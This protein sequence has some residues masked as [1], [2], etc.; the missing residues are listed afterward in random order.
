MDPRLLRTLAAAAAGALAA[1]LAVCLVYAVHPAF[2]DP[3][4]LPRAC[5]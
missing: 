5:R 2:K 4:A 3:G 1:A